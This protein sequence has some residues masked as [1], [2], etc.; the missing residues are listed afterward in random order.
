MAIKYFIFSLLIIATILLSA[1]TIFQKKQIQ[2]KTTILPA[3]TFTNSTMYDINT[4][5]VL[6]IVQSKKA[7]HYKTKDELFDATVVLRSKNKKNETDTIIGKYILKKQD[8]LKFKGDVVLSRN[9]SFILSTPFLNYNLKTRVGQNQHKFKLDYLSHS[10]RGNKLYFDGIND[11]I[12]A[13]NA[14]FKLKEEQ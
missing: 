10:L 9:N 5:E 13:N 4:K 1:T 14:K 12:K 3:I 6:Q 11:I 7:L 2:K 8:K